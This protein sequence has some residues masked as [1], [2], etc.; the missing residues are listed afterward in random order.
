[1]WINRD[2]LDTLFKI[3]QDREEMSLMNVYKGIPINFPASVLQI[4]DESVI[5]R[6][7]PQQIVCLDIERETFINHKSFP[8]IIRSSVMEVSMPKRAAVLSRFE[9]MGN[10]IGNRSEIRVEPHD[11]ISGIMEPKFNPGAAVKGELADISSRGIGFYLEPEFFIPGI[12][13]RSTNI[14]LSFNLPAENSISPVELKLNGIIE[15]V[16]HEM[17]YDR[18]RIGASLEPD[19]NSQSLLNEFIKSRHVDL[20][21]EIQ[22]RIQ[23]S[24]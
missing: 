12:L 23:E 10:N 8:G 7:S 6:T 20:E 2:I 22:N 1:M 4:V 13:V 14:A 9:F 15:N 24:Q 18:Y 17:Y 5:I 3:C 21:Q 11:T 19:Q 16:K